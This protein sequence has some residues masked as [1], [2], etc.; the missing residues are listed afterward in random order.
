MEYKKPTQPL[1]P[2]RS[3]KRS[4]PRNESRI[5][6][7][8]LEQET[9]EFAA[10]LQRDYAEEIARTPREFKKRVLRQLRRHLPPRR[11]RPTDPKTEAALALLRQGK[12]VREI[13]RLQIRGFD[14]LDT[15][16]R[17]LAEKSL[18]QAISRRRQT[19]AR[20]KAPD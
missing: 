6:H 19:A 10:R 4:E 5:T 15:W 11:G 18:R 2:S 9:R 8:S 1:N 14:Q 16:G 17:M 20:D 7:N 3:T 12:S 13:L